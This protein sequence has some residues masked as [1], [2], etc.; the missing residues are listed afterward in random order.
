MNRFPLPALALL[1]CAG[2]ARADSTFTYTL[3][4]A[5]A[6]L[7]G[8]TAT[9]AASGSLTIPATVDGYAVVGIARG[10]FKNRT[11]LTSLAFTGT[12]VTSI[13]PQAFQGCSGLA[14]AALP[15]GLATVPAGA[16]LGCSALT[17]IT[18]PSA[19]TLIE[20]AAFADCVKLSSVSLPTGLTRLGENA[21]QN[22]AALVAAA[23]PS[24]ITALP[25]HVFDGC[26]SLASLSLPATLVSI[27]DA[28][29]AD[30]DALTSL[31]LPASVTAIGAG[32]FRDC[33]NLVTLTFGAGVA[34]LGDDFAGGCD[35]LASI[36]V[37]SGNPA[38]ASADGV[39]FNAA[40]TTVVLVP[41]G[42]AG[43][44]ALPA[45]VTIIGDGAFYYA[46]GLTSI[47]LPDSLATIGA[48]AFGGCNALVTITL[49]TG[50]TTIS[51][52]AFHYAASLVSAIFAGNAPTMGV[53]VFDNTAAGFTIYYRAAASGFTSTVAGYAAAPLATSSVAVAG[54]L[55]EQGYAASMDPASDPE[56]D[57][58]PLLLCYAFGLDPAD[59]PAADLPR[60]EVVDDQLA[61]SFPATASGVT[62]TAQVSANLTDW[63][64]DGVSLSEPDTDG[65]RTA[66]VP[67]SDTRVFIRVLVATE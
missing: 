28:A 2:L 63:T 11:A 20:A 48:W 41:R 55:A 61:L 59:N 40:K 64:T 12:S 9:A 14:S 50:V 25:A 49:P 33:D 4:G 51:D 60:P 27:G 5:Q 45:G 36:S 43:D 58:V 30:A 23:V 26:A 19:A 22:C 39:L 18:L 42:L 57:G 34:T 66:V 3:S 47:T 10:A 62:Y 37:A 17:A 7:T 6:T 65:Y 38:Y 24:G 16:F 8:F 52:D 46:T 53:T 29:L 15:S 54:W 21:F 32:A 56:G 31:T 44:Y 1:A 67:L 35:S 13:G